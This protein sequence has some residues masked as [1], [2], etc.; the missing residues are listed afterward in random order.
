ML[1]NT[2]LKEI[3]KVLIIQYK[4][5]GDILLNT[6]YLPKLRAKFPQAQIDFLIQKPYLTILEDNPFL[7]NLLIMEKK[8]KE[9]PK[10]LERIRIIKKVRQEKYDVIIDQ[11]RGPGSAQIAFFSG[12]KYR[13]GWKLK[14]FNWIYNITEERKNLRY[15]ALLKFDLLRE[16]GITETKDDTFYHVKT[17]SHDKINKWLNEEKLNC[18]E[19]V[20]VSPC[21]PVVYKQWSLDL[22]AETLDRIVNELNLTV[23]LL[24]G[25]NEY[26]SVE[27][28]ARNMLYPVKI[29]PKTSFNEAAALLEKALMFFGNDGG[30][31]HLSVAVKTPSLALFGPHT[32]PVKWQANHKKI[33]KFLKNNKCNDKQ[34]R[35][36]GITC[37]QVISSLKELRR[38]I[39]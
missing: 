13:V 7:D 3:K 12:A 11:L 4:P 14:R 22:Y 26:D 23:V 8:K 15:Y 33:H 32:N 25:P 5:F 36:L 39:S 16:F 21:S 1:S 30:I 35:S 9:I 20:V 37:D 27:Y 2:E 28:I 24:W 18:K 31:N 17:E 10:I 29:A 6:A 38:E 19:F 34:D